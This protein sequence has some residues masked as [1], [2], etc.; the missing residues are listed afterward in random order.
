M[1]VWILVAIGL[2]LMLAL[3]IAFLLNSIQPQMRRPY[4]DTRSKR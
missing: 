4:E 2:M 1:M 3:V